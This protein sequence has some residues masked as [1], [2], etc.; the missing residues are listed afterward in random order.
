MRRVNHLFASS[1]VLIGIL[2]TVE[3]M[4]SCRQTGEDGRRDNYLRSSFQE[5]LIVLGSPGGVDLLVRRRGC[6]LTARFG[7]SC[8]NERCWP[9][10]CS[11][12]IGSLPTKDR[13]VGL[14][15]LIGSRSL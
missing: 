14:C 2:R 4:A 6:F 11:V 15:T 9:W 10:N 12:G 8:G 1:G 13:L 7:E 5:C 3:T